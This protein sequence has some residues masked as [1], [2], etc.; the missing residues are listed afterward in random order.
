[1]PSGVEPHTAYGRACKQC[2]NAKAKCT[3]RGPGYACERC[4]RLKKDCEPPTGARRK[5]GRKPAASRTDQLE[6]RINGL[7]TL[8]ESVP[9]INPQVRAVTD[10]RDGDNNLLNDDN[11]PRGVPT[12][13]SATTTP[14]PSSFS[15]YR[16]PT[17]C[18]RPAHDPHR[19]EVV[20]SA[21]QLE[22]VADVEGIT[23]AT[24][25]S[26]CPPSLGQAN[27]S[28]EILSPQDAE[29][30][31]HRFRNG[32]IRYFPFFR[33]APTAVSYRLR[34]S[35][36]L[37]WLSIMAA[38]APP[39]SAQQKALCA[40]LQGQLSEQAIVRHQRSLDL[41]LGLL[42]FLGWGMYYLQRDPFLLMYC[43]MAVALVQ[44]LGLD[45]PPPTSPSPPPPPP[46]SASPAA[47]SPTSASP[48]KKTDEP[49]PFA[50]VRAHGFAMRLLKLHRVALDIP[51]PS[52]Y[53]HITSAEEMRLTRDFQLRALL[54]QQKEVER[55]QPDIPDILLHTCRFSN[56]AN[57]AAIYGLA[58]YTTAPS[59]SANE[60]LGEGPDTQRAEWLTAC[61]R[62]HKQWY[63]TIFMPQ[64]LPPAQELGRAFA[65]M[66]SFSLLVQLSSFMVAI[67][68][69]ATFTDD[70]RCGWDRELARQHLAI[71]V[72]LD[73]IATR[74]QQAA[75]VTSA[76]NEPLEVG[77]PTESTAEPVCSAFFLRAARV[78]QVIRSSWMA[79]WAKEGEQ[80]Q[81]QTDNGGCRQNQQDVQ[82]QPTTRSSGPMN[83]QMV[84]VDIDVFGGDEFAFNLANGVDAWLTD[85]FTAEWN[86][87]M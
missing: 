35:R 76:T 68:R 21:T 28:I 18:R 43:H 34:Q 53:L 1:M 16:Q 67:Y 31:L 36:P 5:P 23:A 62:L 39:G 64:P 33:I 42:G 82:Q 56:L 54:A 26:D 32:P 65:D 59:V 10:F 78:L 49:H 80:R 55:L 20:Y 45:C 2:A 8:L 86:P 69:L 51:S 85:M 41:L 3:L 66:F 52:A 47:S 25:P 60:R 14:A 84:G 37:L 72:V 46:S 12:P 61:L 75:A 70:D 30:A 44:D 63:D 38:A 58:L 9:R 77:E 83:S 81:Q 74:F 4:L 87:I 15:L 48:S 71:P 13:S 29:E 24:T 19:H 7:M 22:P 73:T 17:T 40:H 11:R 79:A 6:Q 50:C 57:E 27:S